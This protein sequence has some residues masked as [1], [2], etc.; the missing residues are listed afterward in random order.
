[1]SLLK[2][3]AAQIGQSLT[4]TNNFTLYQPASPDGTVR[5]GNGNAG[6]VTDLVVLNS[7]GNLGLG[8]TPS[9]WNG[10]N[11]GQIESNYATLAGRSQTYTTLNAYYNSGWKY[12]GSAAATLY[13]QA[14]GQHQFY[15]APSG[16]SLS[17]RDLLAEFFPYTAE[18]LGSIKTAMSKFAR[19]WAIVISSKDRAYVGPIAA[20]YRAS[21][22]TVPEADLTQVYNKGALALHSLRQILQGV[23]PKED[24]FRSQRQ[25]P[26]VARQAAY[27]NLP[28]RSHAVL[29]DRLPKFR[30]GYFI[31]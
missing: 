26:V 28:P 22:A 30:G 12:I 11:G 3:N 18:Q 7:S 29:D 23:A 1:M 15:T 21:T 5:L 19:P 9:A 10:L 24:L 8:V 13:A 31:F 4:A 17:A 14:S 27:Q 16:K 2:T 20:G 25:K 6:S